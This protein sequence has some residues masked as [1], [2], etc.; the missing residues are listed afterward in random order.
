MP[1]MTSKIH[2]GL[3]N[4]DISRNSC[5]LQL[6]LVH[7][8]LSILKIEFQPIFHGDQNIVVRSYKIIVN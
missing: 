2:M 1:G 7:R 4:I 3:N 8:V 5:A 6:L